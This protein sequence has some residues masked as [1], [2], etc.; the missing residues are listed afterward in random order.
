MGGAASV[1]SF[2]SEAIEFDINTVLATEGGLEC[3]EATERLLRWPM[4]FAE[5]NE[6]RH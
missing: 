2:T 6:T 4:P 1:T 5:N 3:H